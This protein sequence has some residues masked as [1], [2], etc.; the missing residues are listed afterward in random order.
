MPVDTVLHNTKI[1]V[2]GNLVEA[3]LAIDDGKIVKI[4]KETNLPPASIKMNLNGK[5][6]LPGIIDSHVH[7]RDQQLAYK[8]DFLS[9]TSAAA[10]GGVTLVVDM[11]NNDPVT[12]SVLSLKERMKVAEKK[13]LVNIAFNAA[14]PKTMEEIPELIKAGALGFKIFLSKKIGDLDIDDDGLLLKSFL[15]A[16]KNEV[17]VFVHAEDRKI[18]EEKQ[19][20]M[21]LTGRNDIDAYIE[22]HSIAAEVSAIQRIIGLVKKS[23]VH[24][25]FCHISSEIGL[26]II[27]AAKKEGLPVTC[28]ITPHHLFLS[29]QSYRKFGTLALTDPPLRNKNEVLALWSGLKNG[30]IDIVAS[31]HAPHTF[32]EKTRS[33]WEAKPGIPGLETIFPLLM[34]Q[35]TKDRLKLSELVRLTSE[36]PSQI[37]SLKNRGSIKNGNWADVIVVDMKSVYNIDASCFY[38]KAKYSPFDGQQ[39]KGKVIKT[40]VNG[41][42]IMDQDEIYQ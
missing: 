30:L 33:V 35:V 41:I 15:A 2:C 17:T 32:E 14:F 13:A 9:G 7:L 40:F 26:N 31:D 16:A 5:I 1:W 39:V 4:A 24:I 27:E 22:S 18:L 37:F 8:E 21:K 42:L 10:A 38:S 11:P 12:S 3:G 36:N 25:H 23:F 29:S 19:K 20:V 6:T 28:E 34:T